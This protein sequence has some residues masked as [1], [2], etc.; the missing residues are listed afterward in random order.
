LGFVSRFFNTIKNE[1]SFFLSEARF[2]RVSQR[3]CG[4]P[5]IVRLGL[6]LR[7][8]V[9]FGTAGRSCGDD[10]GDEQDEK[11]TILA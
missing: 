2:L 3:L 6:A 5:F 10:R 8:S 4:E 9:R 7:Q 11:D 1:A